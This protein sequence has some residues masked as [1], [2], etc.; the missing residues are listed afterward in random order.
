M[1]INYIHLIDLQARMKMKSQANKLALSYLWW[2][3]EPLL[4]VVMFYFVFSYLLERGG[5]DYFSFLV[6]GKIVFTWFSKSVTLASKSIVQNKGI[7]AQRA[8]PKW[9]FVMAAIQESL[10]K[11][12]F[13]FFVM[14]IIIIFQGYQLNSGWFNL[15]ALTITTYLFICGVGLF[16]SVLV[17]I[18]RDFSNIITLLMMGLMFGSGIFWD[19]NSISNDNMKELLFMVNPLLTIIDLYRDVI[20]HSNP[21]DY[22]KIINILVYAIGLI[23]FSLHILHKYNNFIT[24]KLFS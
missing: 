19:I 13:S 11:T 20:L 3:L 2:V 18:A 23:L 7:I 16:A 15:V 1:L 17:T 22:Y 6:V 9:V 8:I 10:Y 21:M 4:L 14:F 24:R 12:V 5:E